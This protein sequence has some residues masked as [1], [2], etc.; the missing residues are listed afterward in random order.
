[1]ER[2]SGIPI[3]RIF[4][5]ESNYIRFVDVKNIKIKNKQKYLLI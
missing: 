2:L 5:Y 3:F 4:T 1:M